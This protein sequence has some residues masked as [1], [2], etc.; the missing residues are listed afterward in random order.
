MNQFKF[1]PRVSFSGSKAQSGEDDVDFSGRR[2]ILL[3]CALSP[4]A[5]LPDSSFAAA[6]T[7][8]DSWQLGEPIV[9]YWAGPMPMTEAVARQMADGGWNLVWITNRG[10]PAGTAVAAHYLRQL[11]ILKQ[12]GLRGILVLGLWDMN[13]EARRAELTTLIDAVKNHPSLYAYHLKDE[14]STA[15]FEQLKQ[16]RVLITQ[17]DS[18]RLV[19]VN[20]FPIYALNRQLGTTGEYIEAY[21]EYMRLFI[22]AFK[23]QLLS[24]DHYHFAVKGD[25]KEYFLNL[26][27]IRRAALDAG[28]PFMMIVQAAGWKGSMRIPN[29]DELRLLTYTTLA[30][31]A[32]GISHFV[33][34]TPGFDGGMV[35]LADGSPTPLYHSAKLLN[36]EFVAI[37]KQ[38]RSLKSL[39]VFHTGTPPKGVLALPSNAAFRVVSPSANEPVAKSVD[40]LL[41]GYFGQKNVPTHALIV[42]TSYKF[43]VGPLNVSSGDA[44]SS[45]PLQTLVG[46]GPL[47]FFDAATKNWVGTKS[48]QMALQLPPGGGVLVRVK[49]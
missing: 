10:L 41:V 37:A 3:A 8:A 36:K 14:P 43:A 2:N 49:A 4:L 15:L 5:A 9:T 26:N 48:S 12:F 22:D 25:G 30:Y 35:N 42:N 17:S 7:A 11:D 19:Y 20:L 38:T 32:Q 24:F 47:E 27:E 34:G 31:G 6:N 29:G 21:R 40:G 39:D 16:M 46:P 33:Y 23:P 13:N 18:A 1:S 44:A 45:R 28:I